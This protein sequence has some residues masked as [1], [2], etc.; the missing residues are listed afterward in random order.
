MR[1]DRYSQGIELFGS[2]SKNNNGGWVKFEDVLVLQD[3]ISEVEKSNI[4]MTNI[5]NVVLDDKYSTEILNKNIMSKYIT[6][7]ANIS[8]EYQR[9]VLTI[10]AWKSYAAV[11]GSL[12]FIES[13]V[14]FYFY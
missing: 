9:L 4:S 12:L 5:A 8:E 14:I 7:I 13:L 10:S 1:I 2:M 11:L 6:Q 3:K